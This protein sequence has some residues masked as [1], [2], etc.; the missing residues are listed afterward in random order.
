VPRGP[1]R[2]L[3][4]HDHWLSAFLPSHRQAAG[5]PSATLRLL[6]RAEQRAVGLGDFLLARLNCGQIGFDRLCGGNGLRL[7]GV[8]LG[9]RD[10]VLLDE[11]QIADAIPLGALRVGPVLLQP[12]LGR[13][14]IRFRLRSPSQYF[15]AAASEAA[16]RG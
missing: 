2:Q 13:S 8:V 11:R 3:A 12:V 9:A 6:P 16:H 15:L 14:E 4:R 7:A 10:F 5:A 1:P